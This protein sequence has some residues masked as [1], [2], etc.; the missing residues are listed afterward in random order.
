MP[1]MPSG[2]AHDA[3]VLYGCAVFRN[4]FLD[5]TGTG[6]IATVLWPRGPQLTT[7]QIEYLF[8]SDA[9]AELGFDPSVVVEVTELVAGQ[10]RGLR[11]SSGTSDRA[12]SSAAW[13][14]T[15]TR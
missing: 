2:D 8:H 12:P 15:S 7:V 5:I 1:L 9:I 4:L 10:D 14:R 13:T 3:G 11:A 6:A